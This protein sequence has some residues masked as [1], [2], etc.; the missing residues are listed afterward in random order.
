MKRIAI[1]LFLLSILT[2]QAFA[3]EVPDSLWAHPRIMLTPTKLIELRAQRTNS[4]A[5]FTRITTYASAHGRL[6]AYTW[7]YGGLYNSSIMN[8]VTMAEAYA[9]LHSAGVDS[10]RWAQAAYWAFRGI[11]NEGWKAHDCTGGPCDSLT[12]IPE[13]D[14]GYNTRWDLLA[15]ALIYDWCYDGLT[16]AQRT[17][18]RKWITEWSKYVYLGIQNNE[19]YIQEDDPGSNFCT[20]LLQSLLACGYAT[21]YDEQSTVSG[22]TITWPERYL[23]YARDTLFENQMLWLKNEP[24]ILTNDYSGTT[25]S[26]KGGMAEETFPGYVSNS[27]EF[28]ATAINEVMSVEDVTADSLCGTGEPWNIVKNVLFSFVPNTSYAGI[29]RAYYHG[30]ADEGITRGTISSPEWHC[31]NALRGLLIPGTTESRVTKWWLDTWLNTLSWNTTKNW[32]RPLFYNTTDVALA[33][34]SALIGDAAHAAGLKE[35]KYRQTW[36]GVTTSNDISFWLYG[37]ISGGNHTGNDIGGFRINCGSE[38]VSQYRMLA[39]PTFYPAVGSFWAMSGLWVQPEWF[40]VD[41]NCSDGPCNSCTMGFSRIILSGDHGVVEKHYQ[42]TAAHLY[43]SIDVTGAWRNSRM[44]SAMQDFF[45]QLTHKDIEWLYLKADS[46]MVMVDRACTKDANYKRLYVN[47]TGCTSEYSVTNEANMQYS[48]WTNTQPTAYGAGWRIEG[49]SSGPDLIVKATH[50]LD[51]H[52][53]AVNSRV[54]VSTTTPGSVWRMLDTLHAPSRTCVM[55][56]TMKIVPN[57]GPFTWLTTTNTTGNCVVSA[58]RSN[59]TPTLDYL[60]AFSADTAGTDDGGF[61]ENTMVVGYS[62]TARE[63]TRCIVAD[64]IPN[65]M[66][67]W[68]VAGDFNLTF[69]KVMTPGAYTGVLSDSVGIATFDASIVV[70]F[71]DSL[72]IAKPDAHV[73][74]WGWYIIGQPIESKAIR[75]L[76]HTTDTLTGIIRLSKNWWKINDTLTELTYSIPPDE[77]FQFTVS[78]VPRDKGANYD[79]TVEDQTGRFPDILLTGSARGGGIPRGVIFGLVQPTIADGGMRWNGWG[80]RQII[81]FEEPPGGVLLCETVTKSSIAVQGITAA[82]A[83]LHFHTDEYSTAGFRYHATGNNPWV[84][85]RDLDD[86]TQHTISLSGLTGSTTYVAQ[87]NTR[88]M[89]CDTTAYSD[90]TQFV[91][92][93]S[94]ET[95]TPGTFATKAITATGATLTFAS[96]IAAH[97]HFRVKPYGGSWTYHLDDGDSTGHSHA[98]TGLTANYARYQWAALAYLACTADTTT[99]AYATVTDF[100]T[101]CTVQ[102]PADLQTCYSV[103]EATNGFSCLTVGRSCRL[104]FRYALTVIPETYYELTAEATKTTAHWVNAPHLSNS[105]Q[106]TWYWRCVE[107]ECG[108]GASDWNLV[109]NF[110]TTS[111]GHFPTA[112]NPQ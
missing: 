29:W 50:P 64:L 97:A 87:F 95:I 4:E 67:Y 112:C 31:V 30:G 94:C 61:N 23:T 98:I 104:Q 27:L 18:M 78:F 26:G 74:D 105:T 12:F 99:G 11:V 33:P 13:A 58:F 47:T 17:D 102:T 2:V 88:Y 41:A 75:Y 39:S 59:A 51:I 40:G 84:Y 53:S 42:N 86:S 107:D 28:M 43:Y 37:G 3:Y 35:V 66:Y 48:L 1:I 82:E 24:L 96:D 36:S 15:S 19:L 14:N 62:A 71:N 101:K 32:Q 55:S 76:N 9:V 6:E 34:T 65:T 81:P 69:S 80:T 49:T 63:T 93:S 60:V 92:P 52:S 73:S 5:V 68:S 110:T 22:D 57:S 108:V 16:T 91:T 72:Y 90:S 89:T 85:R 77:A 70:A 54:Y 100:Y 103:G 8:A 56:H 83:V 21:M 79:C 7:G 46:V 111:G 25:G 10:T 20:G 45:V 38:L 106:Y 44:Q 109:G